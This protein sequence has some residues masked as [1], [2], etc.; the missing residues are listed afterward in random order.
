[1]RLDHLCDIYWEYDV[2]HEVEQSAH[3]D[4]RIYGQGT[5]TASGRLSG[6]AQWSN[7]HASGQ[8]RTA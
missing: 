7:F 6:K 2:L 1:M 4:G 8:I 5:G 3:G